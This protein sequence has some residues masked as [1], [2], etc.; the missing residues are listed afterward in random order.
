MRGVNVK[1][2]IN[3]H[4]SENKE[5]IVKCGL[6]PEN[7]RV[8]EENKTELIIVHNRGRRRTIIKE[9]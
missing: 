6:V 9:V 4:T 1:Q 5:L 3:R 7:W 8:V 2:Q